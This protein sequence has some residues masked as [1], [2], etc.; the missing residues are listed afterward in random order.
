MC[1]HE[2]TATAVGAF[3]GAVLVG[4]F[5]V[6]PLLQQY[7]GDDPA[8][9]LDGRTTPADVEQSIRNLQTGRRP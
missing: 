3:L 9:L 5:L 1:R 7:M 8:N 2:I 6:R 4:R